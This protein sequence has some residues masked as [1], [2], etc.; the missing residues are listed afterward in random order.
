MAACLIITGIT[1]QGDDCDSSFGGLLKCYITNKSQISAIGKSSNNTITAITL[2]SGAKFYEFEF[3]NVVGAGLE[4]AVQGDA[5]GFVQQ[6]LTMT[7]R[8]MN[9]TKKQVLS[10]LKRGKLA[11]LVQ[12]PD[13]TYKLAGETGFGLQVAGGGALTIS[14][15]VAA[16]DQG[17]ATLSLVGVTLD[18]SNDVSSSI[19]SA[20]VA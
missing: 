20:I 1:G 9:Q 10:K 7:L 17:G 13:G 11:A 12:E 16:T 15:G 6:T 3:D 5:G 19:V 8:N 14:R 2:T 4:E 18:F